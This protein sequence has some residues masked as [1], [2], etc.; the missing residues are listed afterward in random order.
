MTYLTL[1]KMADAAF[2]REIQPGFEIAAGYYGGA[3]AFRIWPRAEWDLFPGYR[4]PI[5]VPSP[6]NKNGTIDG[7]EAVAEL[8]AL[9]VPPDSYT[10][11][12]METLKDRTYVTNFAAT[13]HDEGG[14][15]LWDYGSESTVFSN[16][17]ANGWWVAA[18]S[19]T[20]A[21][22]LHLLE[23]PHVRAW[24]HTANIA[25]GYDASLVK[26]WTEGGM[27]HG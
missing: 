6:G 16:P 15:R 1:A 3:G 18:Y 19:L 22:G 7:R 10:A 8:Q 4:L 26:E 5:Y 12:D 24:Q 20:M 23:S 9:K 2:A 21:Q 17:P 13:L 25:P 27:W 14:Y 11:V